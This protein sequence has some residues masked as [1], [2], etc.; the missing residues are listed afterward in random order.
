ML[1]G[2]AAIVTGAG[3]GIGR[4]IVLRLLAGGVRVAGVGRRQDPLEALAREAREGTAGDA[5]FAAVP[6]DI[7]REEEV[8]RAVEAAHARLGRISILVNNAGVAEY[9]PV[10]R[11]TTEV[12]DRAMETNLRGPFFFTRALLPEML[13]AREGH[14]VMNI[15]VAGV[16]AFGGCGAYGASKAGL[17]GFTRVLREETAGTGVR[18]TAVIPGATDTAMWE[19]PK[20]PPRERLMPARA[21]ADAVLWAL[22]TEASVVPEE[23]LLRP[24][25]GD[26]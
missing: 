1:K 6:C 2:R 17:L 26:L 10:G 22:S 8:H 21:V 19:R 18:V 16:T 23:I 24:E 11:L 13:A 25:G 14:V 3:T 7:R 4:E 5:G 9:G 15:S 20:A 12:W